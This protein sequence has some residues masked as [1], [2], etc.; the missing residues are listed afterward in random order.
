MALYEI[1]VCG[2]CGTEFCTDGGEHTHSCLACGFRTTD[3]VSYPVST[4]VGRVLLAADKA[5]YSD[6]DFVAA[7]DGYKSAVKLQKTEPHS[8]LGLALAE[9]EVI[10]D[11]GTPICVKSGKKPFSKTAEFKKAVKLATGARRAAYMALG[12][13]LDAPIGNND[14]EFITKSGGARFCGYIGSAETVIVPDGTE[15][16]ERFAFL[17]RDSVKRLYIPSSVKNIELQALTKFAPLERIIVSPENKR[18]RVRNSCL[19]DTENCTLV[20]GC[21]D[22]VIPDGGA[23]KTIGGYA[24][25]MC[26]GLSGIDIPNGV[27]EIGAHAFSLCEELERV[28]ISASVCKIENGAFSGCHKLGVFDVERG[29]PVYA[30]KDGCLT[31]VSARKIVRGNPSGIIPYGINK[32]GAGAYDGCEFAALC[33]PAEVDT[34]E[35]GAFIGCGKSE[36]ITVES[37]NKAYF[38]EGN[39]LVERASGRLVLGCRKSVIPSDGSVKEI[40]Q[41]AFRSSDIKSVTLPESVQTVNSGAFADCLE[42]SEVNM[43][44]VKEIYAFAFSCCEELKRVTLSDTLEYLDD[45][46]FDGCSALERIVIPESVTY[47]GKNVFDDCTALK[48]VVFEQPGG[49]FDANADEPIDAHTLG[50]GKAALKLLSDGIE[51]ERR[52]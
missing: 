38:A 8:H 14:A 25:E 10:Y 3:G 23:V 5:L 37:G 22:S 40:G 49:W 29:N 19:I 20:R 15:T 30:V 50:D 16:I 33:I 21:A 28:K 17:S 7:R 11:G 27:T 42:L 9:R 41:D 4:E 39:C 18:Y 34:I 6:C 47:V 44:G 43:Y 24:F 48:S 12:E 35:D 13:K 26:D 52:D 36:S 51:L 2:A 46:A 32:V 1:A 31:D 45:N